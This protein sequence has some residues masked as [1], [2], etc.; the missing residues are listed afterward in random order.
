MKVVLLAS[1][2]GARMRPLSS[3][4]CPKQYVRIGG[5]DSL[6]QKSL[7]RVIKHFSECD[8]FVGTV[9]AHQKL[10]EE[11]IDA[12][13]PSIS[14]NVIYESW[15]IESGATLIHVMRS[16][17][18]RQEIT[19]EDPVCFM[20]I[21]HSIG[22]SA[23]LFSLVQQSVSLVKKGNI[24]GL[25]TPAKSPSSELGYIVL[26]QPESDVSKVVL[27]IEK[28]STEEAQKM[29]D[30]GCAFWNLGI[31]V[32]NWKTVLRALKKKNGD[33]YKF[34]T[35]EKKYA[36]SLKIQSIDQEI[37]EYSNHFYASIYT[38]QWADLG[39]YESLYK[40]SSKDENGNVVLGKVVA[41]NCK[42]CL[43]IGQDQPVEVKNLSQMVY[44]LAGGKLLKRE[45]SL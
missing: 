41:I 8:I 45:L 43:I 18:E 1:G 29:I 2:I 12:I 31:Y 32:M 25:C 22:D 33:G 34:A 24:L 5:D 14:K 39:T 36:Q 40:A 3:K 42:N 7:K 6:F 44:V 15:V 11:Q 26:S 28:P 23:H 19:D 21:D 37:I 10:C 38:N 30:R 13:A 20:P 16:L 35:G 9:K 27:F 17:I 4:Y